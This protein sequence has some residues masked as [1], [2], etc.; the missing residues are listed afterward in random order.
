[1]KSCSVITFLGYKEKNGFT[2]QR[3]LVNEFLDSLSFYSLCS[4][5]KDWHQNHISIAAARN[6]D[7]ESGEVTTKTVL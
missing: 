3:I 7:D 6:D 2:I 1:M 4:V 5:T